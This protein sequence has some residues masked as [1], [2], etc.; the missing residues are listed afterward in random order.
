[1][2]QKK[3]LLLLSLS[4]IFILVGCNL[5]DS[6]FATEEINSP[7]LFVGESENWSAL[8][9]VSQRKNSKNDYTINQVF[10]ITYTGDYEEYT[11]RELK[12]EQI[13]IE[14]FIETANSNND[15]AKRLFGSSSHFQEWIAGTIG[16]SNFKQYVKKDDEFDVIIKWDGRETSFTLRYSDDKSVNLRNLDENEIIKSL[17]KAQLEE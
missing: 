10:N 15:E 7:L 2:F 3:F 5:I 13:S 8:L 12:G 11:N 14:H 1:M 16:H 4:I 6:S 17:Y 9:Y